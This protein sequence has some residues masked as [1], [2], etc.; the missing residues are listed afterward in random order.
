MLTE[1]RFHEEIKSFVERMVSE[2]L[3]WSLCENGKYAKESHL[4]QLPDGR[5]ISAEAHVIYN[6]TYQVPVI[7]FNYFENNGTPLQFSTVVR[8]VL[9]ISEEES[10]AS[11]R[12]RISH[13]EHPFL[14]VLYFNI[15]PCNTS[16]LMK[17]LKTDDTYLLPWFSVYGPQI[18]LRVP[19]F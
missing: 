11:I 5:I 4:E 15:H 17:E 7:W 6:S 10:D 3:N 14:G 9:Q 19:T 16:G 12:T 1:Q 8:D 18:R 13:L 2:K